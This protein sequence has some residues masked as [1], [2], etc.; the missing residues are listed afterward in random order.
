MYVV[1]LSTEVT[2]PVL[3]VGYQNKLHLH[4][5]FKC[6]HATRQPNNVTAQPDWVSTSNQTSTSCMP[7]PSHGGP[8]SV[9]QARLVWYRKPSTPFSPSLPRFGAWSHVRPFP[10]SYKCH[11]GTNSHN[12][13]NKY[14]ITA[15]TFMIVAILIRYDL[16]CCSC[17]PP[18][19][20]FSSWEAAHDQVVGFRIAVHATRIQVQGWRSFAAFYGSTKK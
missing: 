18:N 14:K 15:R 8:D 9:V 17:W 3:H 4:L 6:S 11:D 12:C 7:V 2:R 20:V 10:P 5:S 1:T 19:G 13:I 16:A